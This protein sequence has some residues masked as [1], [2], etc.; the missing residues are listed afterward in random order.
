MIL[1]IRCDSRVCLVGTVVVGLVLV[2]FVFLICFEF[3]VGARR[4]LVVL[5]YL[6]VVVIR[7]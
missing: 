2:G 6:V 1:I 3:W 4:K 7:L 5:T